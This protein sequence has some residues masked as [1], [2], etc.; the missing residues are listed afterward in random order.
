LRPLVV[1]LTVEIVVRA[2]N[3]VGIVVRARRAMVR[4][5]LRARRAM[6]R[7]ARRRVTVA[8]VALVLSRVATVALVR[9]AMAASSA[10]V[11][12]VVLV[13]RA[14]VRIVARDR[15]VPRRAMFLLPRP[16]LRRSLR[17]LA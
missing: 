17:W 6:V 3:R 15:R 2:R 13:R 12:T 10:R 1:A 8:T 7:T 16:R 11:A 9:R 4:I 14:M 5:A